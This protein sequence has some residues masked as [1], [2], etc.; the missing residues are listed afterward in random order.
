MG[1]M[2]K[3]GDVRIGVSGW[4]YKP[5]RGA[6]YPAK[7]PHKRELAFASREM[8]SIEINGTFY[9]LQRPESF[10]RWAEDTPDDFVFAVKGPRFITHILRLREPAA[11]LANFLA[12]GVLR[13]GRKLGPI[14]WQFPPN[15]RFEDPAR[16]AAFFRLLPRDTIAAAALARRHDFRLDG[17]SWLD[18]DAE[19]P[20]RHAMEIRHES[21]VCQEFVDLL[22]E[23]GVALVCADTV[24]WPRLM[25]LTADFAYCRLHGSEELYKSR[26][27][28]DALDSWADLVAAW[29]SGRTPPACSY[30]GRPRDFRRKRDVFVYFDNTDKLQAPGDA[31]RLVARVAAR[32]NAAKDPG[33]DPGR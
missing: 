10:A 25:D 9:S 7:L 26:Y 20:I 28:D 15:F 13:L 23:H 22:R 8:N 33:Q 30:A 16:L 27:A 18:T 17:R 6:F 31:R 21:F 12:S 3:A 32:L 5:W 1:G 29:A 11:P 2:R 19:R 24:E 4:T 14:L